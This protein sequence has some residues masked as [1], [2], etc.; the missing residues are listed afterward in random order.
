[1]FGRRQVKNHSR[2]AAQELGESFGH[3]RMAASHA[4]DGA[5]VALAPRVDAARKA[6]TPTVERAREA[7]TSG[8]ESLLDAA[9]DGRRVAQKQARKTNV[10]AHKA[11]AKAHKKVSKATDVALAKM[12]KRDTRS[13]SGRKWPLMIGGLLAAGAAIGA[14]GALVKRRRSQPTWEEYAADSTRTTTDAHAVLDSAKSA[15]DAGVDKASNAA[16]DRTSDLIGSPGKGKNTGPTGADK[17]ADLN[18]RV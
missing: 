2:M 15:M 17:T 4:A 5:S 16:K 1:M 9:R 6:V 18:G 11:N 7:A 10:K 8:V 12:G 14:T 3:L 13:R